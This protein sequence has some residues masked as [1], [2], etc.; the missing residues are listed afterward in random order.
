MH[1]AE[2]TEKK[3]ILIVEDEKSIAQITAYNLMQAGYAFDIAFDG[4][5]GLKKAINE[6]YDLILLDLM[7][8]KIDGFEVCRQI[9]TKISTPIIIVTARGEE[10]DKV[11]GLDIG[12]DDYVTKPF[13]IKELL[14]RIKANIRRSANEVVVNDIPTKSADIITIRSLVIDNDKYQV[15]K[16]G[17]PIS[18]T[19]KEYELLVFLAQNSGKIFSREEILEKVWGYEGFYGDLQNVDVT[20]SRLR[21]KLESDTTNPEYFFTKR[22]MGYYVK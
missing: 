3:R 16:N 21:K 18:L 14:S 6:D 10:I 19:K 7:L 15:T 11:L 17:D 9:R 4:A 1:M 8:P 22:N 13:K 20:V 2:K 12:A 5:E